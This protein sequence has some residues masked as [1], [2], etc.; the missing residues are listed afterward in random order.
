MPNND[1]GYTSQVVVRQAVGG[2]DTDK[3]GH[4]KVGEQ[5]VFVRGCLDL[6][7]STINVAC[8]ENSSREYRS[9]AL[10]GYIL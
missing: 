3:I 9:S 8:I 4:V 2:E 5:E 1:Y 10:K 7:T 6:A